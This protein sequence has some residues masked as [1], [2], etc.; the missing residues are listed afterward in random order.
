MASSANKAYRQ[1]EEKIEAALREQ[2]TG[3]DLSGDQRGAAKLTELPESLAS[4][5]SCR[6]CTSA[7]TY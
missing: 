4:S 7:A 5:R 3:L 1:A 6:G 2:S